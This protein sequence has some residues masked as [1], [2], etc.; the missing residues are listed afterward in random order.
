MVQTDAHGKVRFNPTLLVTV[1]KETR[2]VKLCN[3]DNNY[4]IIIIIII[5]IMCNYDNIL[6]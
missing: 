4:T 5:I 2:Q 1:L 3:Y 6:F